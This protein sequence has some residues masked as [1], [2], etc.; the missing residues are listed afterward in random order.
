MN[1]L[2]LF[3]M[4]CSAALTIRADEDTEEAQ[5]TRQ[6][7]FLKDRF[8][9]MTLTTKDNGAALKA[10]SDPVLR[11][12]NPVRS[13]TSDGTI[14]LWL[15]GQ[16]PVAICA[17][18]IRHIKP[19]PIVYFEFS[20]LVDQPMTCTRGERTIWEPHRGGLCDQPVPDAAAPA[21]K[22]AQRLIE[23]R[24]IARR[25]EAEFI[26]DNTRTQLRLLPQPAHR[27]QSPDQGTI[28]GGLFAF[29]EANDS[30]MMLMVEAR[31]AGKDRSAQWRYTLARTSSLPMSVRLD[32]KEVFAPSGYWRNPRTLADPYIEAFDGEFRAEEL[33][34]LNAAR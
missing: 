5:R 9:T 31:T 28:D 24:A 11:Y 19:P 1:R 8:A 16:R 32:G 30:E 23:M 4:V 2:L 20:S 29:V 33:P 27:F 26:K 18:S 25:F 13:S 34:P 14:F 7:Q 6:L 22:P 15:D 17:Y 12:T 10:T 21:D 3:L